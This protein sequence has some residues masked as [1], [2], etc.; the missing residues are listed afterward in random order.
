[1]PLRLEGLVD[2]WSPDASES[3]D[4]TLRDAKCEGV[5]KELRD[6]FVFAAADFLR[7]TETV[8]VRAKL[9]FQALALVG[10]AARV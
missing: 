9:G 1:M 10:H 5:R 8:T 4:L 6:C 7:L 3:G 2:P